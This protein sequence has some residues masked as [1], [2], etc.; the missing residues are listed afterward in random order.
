MT[1]KNF[2]LD[3]LFNATAKEYPKARATSTA[4]AFPTYMYLSFIGL[5]N[6]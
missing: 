6:L 2:S 1:V 3:N 5:V 4:T